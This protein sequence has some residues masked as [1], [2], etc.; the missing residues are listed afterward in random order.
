[1]ANE[2][3]TENIVR[4]K[5]EATGITDI[6]G[7][8]IEEQKSQNPVIEKLLKKASK[9]G[10]GAGKP[11]FIISQNNN[12]DF[13]LVI[14]CKA[15]FKKHI[16]ST[17]DQYKDY[18]VDGV[19]LYASH[20]AQEYNIIAIAVSGQTKNELKISTFIFPK[21]FGAY[22]ILTDTRKILID[23]I[24]SWQ[25]YI[26]FATYDE[27]L[28][29]SR[30]SDLN[31]FSRDLHDYIRDY[32]KITEA[33]KPLLVSGIL[34]ALMEKGFKV[35]Y[36]KY[37]EAELAKKTFQAVKDIIGMAKLGVNQ[38]RKKNAIINAFRFIEDH[39]ELQK[40][41]RKKN[42]SPLAHIVREID[43]E[44]RPFTQ[45]H[46]DYDIIGNFYGEFIRYTG[47]DAQGLGIVL[48]PKHITEIF[49]DLA[50]LNKNSIVLDT[51]C[52]TGGFLISAMKKMT[53]GAS[54]IE[55]LKIL[56]NSLIGVEQEPSMFA[57]AVSNMILRGDGKT[58]LYQGSCFD[59]EIFNQIKNKATAGF[60]NPPYSQK[61]E[62]LHEWNFVIQLLNALQK[63][64]TGII[65]V[66][67]SLAIA[68]HPLREQILREHRLEAV[69]SM[70][71]DLFY[72]VGMV[73][74][75][76]VF[77]AHVPHD[78]DP[79]HESWFGYW[80]DDGFRKD[81]TQGRILTEKWS[82]VRRE[83]IVNFTNKKITPGVSIRKKIGMNNEW[84]AEAY[85][86]TDF[87]NLNEI[88]FIK[89]TVNLA[90]FLFK[91]GKSEMAEFLLKN[92]NSNKKMSLDIK[93]WKWFNLGNLFTFE[94]GERLTKLDRISGD[95][96]L[97]TASENNNGIAGFISL[98]N[99]ENKKK[100]FEN[101][102]T[103]DMFFNVFYHDYKYFSD[104]NIHTLIPIKFE[105][106]KYNALFLVTVLSKLK[107]KYAYGRQVRLM[108]LP[109]EKIKLP[110]DKKG[111]PDWQFM[112]NYIKSL[113]YSA[114]L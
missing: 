2:R 20:L 50:K 72:P 75:I 19:L 71:N 29:K 113:P 95:I 16:S 23:D 73:S 5:L 86:E 61:G 33:Q 102:I 107:Y 76:M 96:P 80:K 4:K 97:I 47:G 45:D 63:N 100:I 88:D 32:G 31:K 94:K 85:L 27:S 30:K 48:T 81:K 11:E 39:P 44:V 57:L 74:C 36:P 58:N 49:A 28:A 101:K 104:D 109:F 64:A 105:L 68:P 54:E 22:S 55:R 60:I 37:E 6:N 70:P 111:N 92:K 3:I 103:I 112:E 79:H 93:K 10:N 34:L 67:M 65:I 52:G 114:S 8:L 82:K 38:E 87:H 84:C 21:G 62:N 26:R 99:F 1:M 90:S 40:I 17:K 110:V 35:A 59:D 7:F 108:R 46:Y 15:D 77:T 9:S 14:E 89:N 66:P 24:I 69:M 41:D 43:N 106:N 12:R 51:C 56:E 91:N 53:A 25:D 42:E 18:A 13:L 98:E 78:S 83:W